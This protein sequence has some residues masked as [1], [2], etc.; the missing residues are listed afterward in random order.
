MSHEKRS[1]CSR[2]RQWV[3][4][5]KITVRFADDDPYESCVCESC[6]MNK[7]TL[8]CGMPVRKT[9][10]S[11]P[12]CVREYQ[13]CRKCGNYIDFECTLCDNNPCDSQ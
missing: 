8:P 3:P 5:A 1:F 4:D 13:D 11:A 12:T 6:E 7:T 9:C 2:C 10:A